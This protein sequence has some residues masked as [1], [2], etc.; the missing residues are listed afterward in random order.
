MAGRLL[1][2]ACIAVGALLSHQRTTVQAKVSISR[3]VDIDGQPYYL[4]S[5]VYASFPE[6]ISDE[7][8]P[9]SVITT[10][11]STITDALVES[12]IQ[13]WESTDDVFTNSFL[14]GV[15]LINAG[16]GI[17]NLSPSVLP[18]LQSKGV[19]KLFVS[20][21]CLTPSSCEVTSSTGLSNIRSFFKSVLH[22]KDQSFSVVSAS[23]D[24]D[25]SPY[26]GVPSRIYSEAADKNEL[27]LA[28]V[29]VSVKDIYFLKGLK[30]SCG[31]R[32]F[33]SLYPRRNSTGPAVSRLLDLGA[34]IIG[35]TKTVQF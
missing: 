4:P 10:N 35:M 25:S 30:T 20:G 7:V 17:A 26:I 16:E 32:A 34:D 31:N 33:Y 8:L 22:L 14:Q 2:A 11:V 28:G 24:T 6:T 18:F 13:A 15:L 19:Q 12:T 5:E 27:P 9:L 29:R 1:A 3:T 21:V 23:L